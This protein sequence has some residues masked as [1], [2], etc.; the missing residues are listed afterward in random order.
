MV[1]RKG[2]NQQLHNYQAIR[3]LIHGLNE[4]VPEGNESV[5]EMRC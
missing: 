3:Y 1:G 5:S 4:R 2:M